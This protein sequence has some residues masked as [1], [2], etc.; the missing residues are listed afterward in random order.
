DVWSR[1]GVNTLRERAYSVQGGVTAALAPELTRGAIWDALYDRRTYATSGE[2]MLL[3]VYVENAASAGPS[4]AR[5]A[6][7]HLSAGAPPAA[8]RVGRLSMGQAGTASEAP[9]FRVQASGTA[10]LDL[11]EIIRDDRCVQRWTLE[12]GTWDVDLT[13]TDAHPLRE[14]AAYYVRVTQSGFAFAWSGPIWL[15]CPEHGTT[16]RESPDVAALPAWDAGTWPPPG[17]ETARTEAAS[18]VPELERFLA[19]QGAGRRYVDLD[20]VGMFQEHRG[21]YALYRGYDVGG[22]VH[23]T[24]ITLDRLQQA[25]MAA[26]APRKRTPVHVLYYPGFPEPRIRVGVGWADYG[27]GR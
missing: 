15:A 6:R 24:S 16:T 22:P 23:S 25:A 5:H 19:S 17:D 4:D 11:V 8:G 7:A 27:A 14:E 21:R 26:A 20:P 2:R 3:D 18:H 12:P 9:R 13:W 10:P 1:H